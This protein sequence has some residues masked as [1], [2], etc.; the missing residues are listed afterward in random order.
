MV[1]HMLRRLVGDDAFFQGIR[2]FYAESRFEKAGTDDL[3]RAMEAESSKSLGRFF[4]RW[5]YGAT[6]PQL[7][8]TSR[9]EKGAAGDELV[10]RFDQ[11]GDIF[12][13]PLTV[14][15]NYTDRTT[16]DVV[17]AV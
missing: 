4:D 5:I 14:T 8:F 2:R 17:V 15:L 3:R 9:V 6:L 1:L 7:S 10:A 12:D 13:V 11:A 16:A